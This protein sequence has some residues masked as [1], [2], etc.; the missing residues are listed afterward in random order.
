MLKRKVEADMKRVRRASQ[1]S[2]QTEHIY[3]ECQYST[4]KTWPWPR[5]VIYKAEV[6]WGEG[7]EPKDNPR[8]VV[9]NMKQSPHS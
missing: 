6:V 3:G 9:T 2:E 7:K 5:R 1:N 4:K 8:F